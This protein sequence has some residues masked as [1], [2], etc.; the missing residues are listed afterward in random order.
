MEG[1]EDP[2]DSCL[3]AGALGPISNKSYCSRES[4]RIVYSQCSA[5]GEE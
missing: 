3:L 5:R 1:P 4:D 2:H